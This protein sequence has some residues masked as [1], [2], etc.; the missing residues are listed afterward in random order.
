MQTTIT[1]IMRIYTS[2]MGRNEQTNQTKPNRRIFIF[3]KRFISFP[4]TFVCYVCRRLE[5][6]NE[7]KQAN[8]LAHSPTF[9]CVFLFLFSIVCCVSGRKKEV[10]RTKTKEWNVFA[11]C[12]KNHNW[13]HREE[14]QCKHPTTMSTSKIIVISFRSPAL[15]IL[16]SI[17]L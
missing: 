9:V 2:I 5:T 3:V 16:F 17:F 7:C 12:C 11:I 6:A 14:T 15:H 8:I 10:G 4:P 1:I 13:T